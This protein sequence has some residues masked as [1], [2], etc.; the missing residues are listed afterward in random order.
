MSEIEDTRDRLLRKLRQETPQ[1][2][3]YDAYFEGEQPLKFLAPQLKQELGERVTELIINTPRFGVEAY[4]NRLDVEGFRFGGQ[5]SSDDELWAVHQ[6]NDGDLLTQQVHRESLALSRAYTIVGPGDSG[7]PLITAQSPFQAIHEDDPRTHDV[8]NGLLVWRELDNSQWSNV[9]HPNGRFTWVRKNG[10]SEWK[11]DS[12]EENDYNLCRMVPM[13]NDPRTLGRF[14]PGKSDQRL[15]RSVF[16]DI[17]PIADAINKMATDM[18]V[19]GEFHAMPRRWATGLSEADFVDEL[20]GEQLETF[21]LIAGRIWASE[22]KEAKYGQFNETDLA[23]FHNTIKL[24][25]QLA[26]QMLALPPHYLTFTGENPASADAIRSAEV[27]LVKRAERKQ[28][29]LSTRWE[30]VQRLVLLEL[31]YPDSPETRQIE[32]LWR[33]PSTP[34]VAQKADAVVKLVGAKDSQGRSIVPVPQA[35]EDLGYS[36]TQRKR[37]A[38]WDSEMPADPQISAALR[39]LNE[40]GS[41]NA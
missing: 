21:S 4:E 17:I 35:R 39:G 19:S 37:M 18:M 34:T 11:L 22:N 2:K 5:E 33:D 7:V 32:T 1:L 40:A 10:K 30:R 26:A 23:V 27:Q 12:K 9:Y 15:G 24:L 36:F 20:T 25:M 28:A 3:S 41:G 13:I 8:R 38:E 31:G 29:I 14:R 16:H 6:H